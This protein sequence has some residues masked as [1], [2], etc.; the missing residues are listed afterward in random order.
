MQS[1][2]SK[3]EVCVANSCARCAR[4]ACRTQACRQLVYKLTSTRR[5]VCGYPTLALRSPCV[6]PTIAIRL[7]YDH[8]VCYAFDVRLACVRPMSC[9]CVCAARV[10]ACVRTG[11]GD[12]GNGDHVTDDDDDDDGGLLTHKNVTPL[13]EAHPVG[14]TRLHIFY[15]TYT[16]HV[17]TIA[18]RT[19]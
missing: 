14:N 6:C 3:R 15:K 13:R 11:G 5:Q 9:A 7:L 4:D 8:Y 17:N 10:R 2:A 18:V 19:C 1:H 12:D 16:I